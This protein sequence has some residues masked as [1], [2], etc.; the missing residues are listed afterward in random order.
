M[1]APF[2]DP[3]PVP[4]ERGYFPGL[5]AWMST[6]DSAQTTALEYHPGLGAVA[7]DIESAGLDPFTTKCVTL[8]W[9]GAR[10]T[11]T[12]LLD[13]RDPVQLA[14][15]AKVTA[16]AAPELVMHNA[17]Y[18]TPALVVHGMLALDDVAKVTDTIVLARMVHTDKNDRKDLTSL[19]VHHLGV[20][21]PEGS[22]TESFKAAGLATQDAGWYAMDIGVPIYRYGAMA[23]TVLTLRLLNPLR[24]A[25]WS[26]LVEGHPFGD[27][28]ADSDTALHLMER[29]QRVNRIM[30]RRSS[31]GLEVD[32]EYLATYQDQHAVEL[33]QAT[34]ALERLGLT[35]GQGVQ[36]LELLESRGELPAD[37]PRTANTGRLQAT[38]ATM[39][40]LEG[41]DHPLA[42][43]HRV[44]Q[45]KT[46][47]QGYLEK[48]SS[49]VLV[50]G[51]LHH[52]VSVLGASATGRMSYS[53]PELQQFPAE[54]RPIIVD[55]AGLTSVDWS[56]IEPVVMANAAGDVDFLAPFER[57]DDLYAHVMT[58]AGVERKVAKVVL[59]ASMYGQGRAK[60]AGSLKTTED[61]ASA[62]K[63]RVMGAMPVTA[64]F[65]DQVSQLGSKS[66]KIVTVSGRVQSIPRDATGK[67]MGYRAVNYFCQGSA[68]D[69]LS[70]TLVRLDD[71]GLSDA[72][73]LAMH[74]E[75]V[76][77]T[78]HA[79]A[80][81]QAMETV[82][83]R[84]GMWSRRIHAD[85]TPVLRTDANDMGRAW[86][87]V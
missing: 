18:D 30:L 13:P 71:W 7:I 20:P 83:E 38:K 46:K 50:T 79:A 35:P 14:T 82:P 4:D 10:G 63:S 25:V 21:R 48:V 87:Y 39:A 59:L 75:I 58:A 22:L 15:V 5:S 67:F 33:A 70:E 61:Q 74:D 3:V 17:A 41:M 53:T 55:S 52:Q 23:D 31:I 32:T 56:S 28:G 69:V 65:M 36:V 54:A 26:H 62:I 72:V 85:R 29:E 47:V 34:N 81:R 8:A 60:L 24:A 44:F 2:L 68:Y 1:R 12:V 37:W 76:C 77:T 19:A 49:M 78:E 64:R 57:G 86:Q 80:V 11:E 9:Q 6:G 27:L 16:A 43:A 42:N 51:R 73:R 66:G 84:L 45:E 40:R